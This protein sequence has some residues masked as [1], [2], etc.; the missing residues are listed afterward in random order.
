MSTKATATM[1]NPWMLDVDGVGVVEIRSTGPYIAR[2]AKDGDD[3]WPFWYVAG[4]DNRRNVACFGNGAV[5][6]SRDTAELVAS[7]ANK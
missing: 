1:T 6:C 4:P 3:E 5:M 7:V 2:P